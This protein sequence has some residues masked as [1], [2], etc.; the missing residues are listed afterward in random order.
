MV[1]NYSVKVDAFVEEKGRRVPFSLRITEPRKS[2]G[3]EEYYCEICAPK[4]FQNTKNIY[5]VDKSQA[6][7]LALEFVKSLLKG[8]RLFDKNG[9]VIRV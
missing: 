5:G 3:E 8:R 1:E 7:N 4:L 6:K 9:R 2:D